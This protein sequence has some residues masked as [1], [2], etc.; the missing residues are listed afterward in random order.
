[1]CAS[2]ARIGAVPRHDL[3]V[4]ALDRAI[5]RHLQAD[6][7]LTNVELAERVRLSPSQCLRRVRSLERAGVPDV[8]EA[9]DG[10]AIIGVDSQGSYLQHYYDSRGVTRLYSMTFED[11][12]WTLLRD[13]P[14]FTPLDFAQRYVGQL[15]P[16]GDTI[17]GRWEI[18]DDGSSWRVDFTLTLRRLA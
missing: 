12:S 5:L 17:D 15:S 3:P 18:S 10:L 13:K 2:R 7:R 14:D 16:D 4:D 9:P 6:G 1:M 8:P 11:G